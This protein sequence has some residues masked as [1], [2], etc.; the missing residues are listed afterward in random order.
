MRSVASAAALG[1]SAGDM[2]AKPTGNNPA[3]WFAGLRVYP[4]RFVFHTLLNFETPNAFLWIRS[5]VD[6]DRHEC[7]I[8]LSFGFVPWALQV[9]PEV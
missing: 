2:D 8:I 1:L 6:V 5:F 9:F 7:K 3:H 4:K